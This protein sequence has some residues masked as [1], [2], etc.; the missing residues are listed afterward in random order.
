M[1]MPLLCHV[2]KANLVKSRHEAPNYQ[3]CSHCPVD[4]AVS[5]WDWE[6]EECAITEERFLVD[7]WKSG[8]GKVEGVR[9]LM[10]WK[11]WSWLGD[12][13]WFPFSRREWVWWVV[14]WV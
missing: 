12:G 4:D 1:E 3:C 6:F 8:D 11:T 5:R 14:V 2:R 10:S 7:L 9:R 13:E